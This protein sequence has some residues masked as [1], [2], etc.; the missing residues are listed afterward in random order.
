MAIHLRQICIAA[1]SLAPVVE[2]VKA[3]LGLEVCF[4]DPGVATFGLENA[5]LPVGSQFLEVVAPVREKTAVSRYLE[6]RD[7]DGGYMVIC[8]CEGAEEQVMCRGRAAARGIRVAFEHAHADG[9]IMQFHPG[10]TGGTFLEIDWDKHKD[11]QQNWEPAGG[12]AW[13]RYVR[14]H[15]VNAITGAEIQADRPGELAERWAFVTGVP[16]IRTAVDKWTLRLANATLRIVP[17]QDDRGEGLGGIDLAV[18]DPQRLFTAARE[19]KLRLHNDHF[20]LGGLRI[21]V[22]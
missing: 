15:I 3:V 2:D 17:V 16:A 18:T 19:R 21:Y 10:D 5:L 4:V 13:A 6:R 11:P 1:K 8:Q 9:H 7:G 20:M 22:T 14:T 12:R